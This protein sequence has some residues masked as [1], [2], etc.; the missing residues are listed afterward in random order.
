MDQPEPAAYD[1]GVPEY[2]FDPGGAGFAYDIKILGFLS[3]QQIP[4][5]AADYVGFK[6]VSPQPLDDIH[7]VAIH[8]GQ[9]DSMLVL[10]INN[11][12]FNRFP[13]FFRPVSDAQ[14]VS[15]SLQNK[16]CYTRSL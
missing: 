8:I 15:P 14:G 5:R 6:A 1:P 2:S 10:C 9:I 3:Q 16:G 12:F 4:D 7:R 11:G 13:V